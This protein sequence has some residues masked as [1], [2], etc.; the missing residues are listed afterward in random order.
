MKNRLSI[1]LVLIGA[2]LDRHGHYPKGPITAEK[3]VDDDD[4]LLM[5]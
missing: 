1:R 5:T 2:G 3:N 4:D